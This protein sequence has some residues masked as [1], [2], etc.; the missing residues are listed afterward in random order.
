MSSSGPS[1]DSVVESARGKMQYVRLGTSGL[2]VSKICLGMMS[3][4][5]K[6]IMDWSLEEDKAL[7]LI[8]A[9]HD[10]GINFFDT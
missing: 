6:K 7:P 5:S 1:L 4:G 9:A 3:Y 10:A 8:A 2:Q